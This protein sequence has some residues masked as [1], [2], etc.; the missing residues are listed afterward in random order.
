MHYETH[1]IGPLFVHGIKLQK[2]SSLV[3][4]YPSHEMDEPY[5]WSNSLILRLPWLRQGL[6]L[7]LW[8]STSR[9]EEQ[10]ILQALAGRHMTDSEFSQAEKTHIRRNMIR[11]QYSAEDQELLVGA[12][13]L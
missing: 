7:G 1:S 4:V 3:H 8:R 6:V 5:R 11:K 10:A 2:K 13:D 9:T 12:L